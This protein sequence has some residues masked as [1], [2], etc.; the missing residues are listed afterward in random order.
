MNLEKS[1]QKYKE[2]TLKLI[3]S[4]GN[5][6]EI[7]KLINARQ[8]IINN[9]KLEQYD[10][11]KFGEIATKLDLSHIEEELINKIKK[12]KVNAKSALNNVRKL[13]QARNIYNKEA[14]YPLFF[15]KTSY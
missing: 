4:V 7:E 5:I 2:L 6:D 13:K 12:E 1:L 15:N 3:D 11:D 9:I 8:E 14:S 10:K